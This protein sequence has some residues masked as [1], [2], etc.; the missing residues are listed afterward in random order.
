MLVDILNKMVEVYS[1]FTH[2][3][4]YRYIVCYILCLILDQITW[5]CTKK[6]KLILRFECWELS[7]GT[8]RI[9]Q[10][11]FNTLGMEM[12]Y[13]MFLELRLHE[14]YS[15]ASFFIP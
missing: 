3:Y 1:L 15:P 10:Q 7:L 8:S 9:Q 14:V 2:M 12:E 13:R 5:K 6:D 11:M 4:R